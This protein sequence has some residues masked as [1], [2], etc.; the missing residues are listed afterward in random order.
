[1]SIPGA[2][3]YNF[4]AAVFQLC[5]IALDPSGPNARHRAIAGVGGFLAINA[6]TY[7][8]SRWA[9]SD[10]E[11]SSDGANQTEGK[12][13]FIIQLV[14]WPC[15]IGYVIAFAACSSYGNA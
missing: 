14:G 13:D 5:M 9:F 4:L 10:S 3:P 12:A 8:V 1:M 6:L 7:C 11:I 15:I 2:A